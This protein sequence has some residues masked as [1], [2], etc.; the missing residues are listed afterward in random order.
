MLLFFVKGPP[1]GGNKIRRYCGAVD[2]RLSMKLGSKYSKSCRKQ[3]T[4]MDLKRFTQFPSRKKMTNE[5]E[6][7]RENAEN[8][9]QVMRKSGQDGRATD[10]VDNNDSNG[11]H[12][13]V[14]AGFC[15]RFARGTTKEQDSIP[16]PVPCLSL[17]LSDPSGSGTTLACE[18]PDLHPCKNPSQSALNPIMT[19]RAIDIFYGENNP[20]SWRR[21]QRRS[22]G[23]AAPHELLH[24]AGPT[25]ARVVTGSGSRIACALHWRRQENAR[26]NRQQR[27][28]IVVGNARKMLL[29]TLSGL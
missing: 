26:K 29:P 22:L 18:P 25:S 6:T 7:G 5:V 4:A 10:G 20:I 19:S 14:S 13:S 17:S 3:L 9:G 16:L 2:L 28:S 1:T 23:C 8:H 21:C 24:P 11:W 12:K 15:G 27:I